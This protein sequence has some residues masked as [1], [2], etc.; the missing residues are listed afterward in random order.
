[1][2]NLH[3]I[4]AVLMM[5]FVYAECSEIDNQEDCERVEGCEWIQSDNMPDGGSCIEGEWDEEEEWEE[6][7]E[8]D[9]QEDCERAEWCE[10]S[11]NA[12][13]IEGEW[14]DDDEGDD[15]EEW[16]CEDIESQLECEY[17]EGCEWINDSCESKD[18]DGGALNNDTDLVYNLLKNYPNPFNPETTINFSISEPSEISLKIYNMYGKEVCNLIS[19]F[20]LSG[21]YS[22]KWN[23]VDNDGNELSSG[24]YIYQLSTKN[25][26]Y[27]NRMVLI[28]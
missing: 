7:S 20:Y 16:P 2:K 25:S 14:D 18:D 13:C 9:N 27:S 4:L 15:E 17:S 1:M 10:W 19:D 22:V 28:K 3:Y 12:G 11:E 8:I 21:N 24:I 6:C 5:N 23:A 26:T